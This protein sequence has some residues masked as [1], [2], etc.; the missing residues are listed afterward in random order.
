[1]RTLLF[2]MLFTSTVAIAQSSDTLNGYSSKI[3]GEEITYFSPYHRFAK[4][5][6][7]TRCN[8]TSTISW[9]AQVSSKKKKTVTY[10]FLIGHSTGTSSGI[11]HF[12]AKLNG[13]HV[14]TVTTYPRVA[15]TQD[16]GIE[17][18]KKVKTDFVH[19]AHDVNGDEFGKLY[20]T[21]PAKWLKEKQVF[22]ITGRNEESRDW[23]MIFQFQKGFKVEA[24]STQLVTREEN[25]RQLNVYLDQPYAISKKITVHSSQFDTTILVKPGYNKLSLPVYSPSFVGT[26]ALTFTLESGEQISAQVA[27]E[28]VKSYRFCIIHHSHN[29]IGYSHLQTEVARIQTENIRTAMRWISDSKWRTARYLHMPVWHIESLWAVE[30]FMNEASELERNMF[31][32]YVKSG[33]IVLSANYANVLTGLSSSEELNWMVE[34][35]KR[36]EKEYGFEIQNAMITDIPGVS[37]SALNAYVRNEIPYLALGPNYVENQADKGDRVGGIIR[38]QGDRAFYW[39]PNP[40]SD[41]KLLV[42]TAGK[43]YSYFHNILD[44]VKEEGWE[45][46]ISD[47]CLELDNEKYPYDMVQ[48][49]YTKK[50]DNGPVDTNLCTFIDEWNSRYSSPKLELSSVNELFSEFEKQYGSTLPVETGEMSPYWEDGAYSTATEEIANRMLSLQTV[51]LEKAAK[52]KGLFPKYEKEFQALHRNIILFHEHTWGSWCSISDPEISF[53]TEQWRIKKSFLDSAQAQYD[54]L[55]AALQIPFDFA[56]KKGKLP[57]TDFTVNS[58]TGGLSSVIVDGKNIVGSSTGHSLFEPVYVLGISSPETSVPNG[59]IISNERETQ[60]A[61]TVEVHTTMACMPDIAIF[62]FLD[63]R[64]NQLMVSYRIDK[65]I[66]KN[67][68]SM[69]IALPFNANTTDILYGSTE[70]PISLKTAQL[71][72]SNREFICTE[73][74]ITLQ[75]DGPKITIESPMVNLFEVGGIIDETKVNGSKVWKREQGS[76]NDLYLYVFNNYWHTNYKAYQEGQ[77]GFMMSVTFE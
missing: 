69:H 33:M 50:A 52:E 57:I 60:F 65:H 41:K 56:A 31:V 64:N 42:W 28:P 51:T 35:A 59:I 43:G 40:Q 13:V 53:T 37:W 20:V 9:N 27:L 17:S 32:N 21:I 54:R 8:G 77:I 55:S 76:L 67:K 58:R 12:D 3:A 72:G 15:E 30:N 49:R 45:Q 47:Y 46:R 11:R 1:M 29:D 26:D 10:E 5:A 63:K 16:I 48:L 34:Y 62:Y 19:L 74:R 38:E 36:L 23:F 25:K 71:P 18:V 66:E 70:T 14:F 24:E 39:K 73:E 68:E 61:K 6:L 2:L 7:L 22:E 4:T 75:T 44:D